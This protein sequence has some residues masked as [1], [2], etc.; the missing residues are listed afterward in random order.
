MEAIYK[1]KE[2]LQ[3]LISGLNGHPIEFDCYSSTDKEESQI[4]RDSR[5]SSAGVPST[6]GTSNAPPIVPIHLKTEKVTKKKKR[7]E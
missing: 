2:L 5:P 3:N 4:Y 6:K 7:F 1:R